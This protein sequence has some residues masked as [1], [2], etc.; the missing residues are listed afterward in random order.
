MN[1]IFRY[2]FDQIGCRAVVAR[3]SE[4]NTRVIRIWRALG[5]TQ[6]KIP[7][8]RGPNEA[9]VVAVLTATLGG[10]ANS[11]NVSPNLAQLNV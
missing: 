6:T 1:V 5:A 10:K 2:P 7:E 9:E 8:L 11:G 4:Q 3:H